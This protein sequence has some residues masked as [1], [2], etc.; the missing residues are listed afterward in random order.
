MLRIKRPNIKLYPIWFFLLFFAFSIAGSNLYIVNTAL[1]FRNIFFPLLLILIFGLKNVKISRNQTNLL[2]PIILFYLIGLL[3]LFYQSKFNVD[4]LKDLFY[5]SFIPIQFIIILLLGNK[6]QNTFYENIYKLSQFL[7]YVLFAIT[8]FE[9]LTNKHLP[10]HN[11]LSLLTPTAFFTNP[12][13]LSVIAISIY[14]ILMTLNRR[15]NKRMDLFISLITGVIIFLTLSRLSLLVF[16]LLALTKFLSVKYLKRVFLLA[17]IVGI[18]LLIVSNIKVPEKS[19]SLID[20]SIIRMNSILNFTEQK[21]NKISSVSIRLEIYNIPFKNA[22]DFIIGKGFNSDEEILNKY[23]SET[24]P[25]V[26]SHSFFIQSIFY[27]GWFGFLVLLTFFIL[28][29]L[30]SVT[31]S[32]ISKYFLYIILSQMLIIN[33]PSSI[34][35]MPVIWIPFFI[36]IS[37]FTSKEINE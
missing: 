28:L 6:Y 2:V 32:G 31:N 25:I 13:D 20:R 7:L 8:I 17:G 22:E 4:V 29:I 36:I 18:F 33:I 30:Y 9:V 35:R 10:S 27:F 16:V 14:V 23:K 1:S 11:I 26:N 21:E 34:I 3:T 24:N 12:N 19:E 37:Y 15:S 5:F